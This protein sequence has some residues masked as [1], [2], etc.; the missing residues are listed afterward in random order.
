MRNKKD[1]KD[2]VM[3]IGMEYGLIT[4]EIMDQ[5]A[6]NVRLVVEESMLARDKKVGQAI[7]TLV[8]LDVL[9]SC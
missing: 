9:N 1:A 3:D 5:R 4:K 8:C 2:A 7:K 6:P